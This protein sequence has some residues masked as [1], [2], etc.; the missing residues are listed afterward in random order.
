MIYSDVLEINQQLRQ[1]ISNSYSLGVWKDQYHKFPIPIV[2]ENNDIVLISHS[3]MNFY[4]ILEWMQDISVEQSHVPNLPWQLLQ[5]FPYLPFH[6]E[7]SSFDIITTNQI[8]LILVVL[9]LHL[10]HPIL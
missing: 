9:V 8:I 5:S 7:N 2:D 6:M 3:S 10:Q 4:D 1:V